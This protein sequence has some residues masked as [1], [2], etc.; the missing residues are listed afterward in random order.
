VRVTVWGC[1]GSIPTPGPATVRYG[2]NTSCLEV[3][4]GDECVLVFDAGTGIRPLGLE[5]RRRGA[6]RLHLLL[7]HLHLD[8][9]EGLRFFEPLWDER[10]AIEI[11]GPPS[12]VLSLRDRIARA[13]SPPL[14]PVDLGDVPA[15]VTFHDVPRESWQIGGAELT[16]TFVV[17]PGPTVGYRI[18]SGG[19][20]LAYIPDH[21]PAF[22]GSIAGRS[23]D[24]ISGSSIAADADVLL[25]D[26]Q[27]SEDEYAHR[28]GWGHSSVADAVAFTHAVGARQLFLFHHDPLHSDGSLEEL[29][30]HARALSANGASPTLAHEGMVLELG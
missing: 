14:F 2:G 1:R 18:E 3:V 26:A 10:V 15:R 11:W 23:G 25:H 13:F 6:R 29:E 27:Y 22:A 19:V 17:H 12:P 20:S 21:E 8:H 5:L 7:T 4:V 30:A 9:L 16:A 28:V 24:W